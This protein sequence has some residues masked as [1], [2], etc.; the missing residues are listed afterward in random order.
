LKKQAKESC[1]SV[2]ATV[3][4]LI[5]E[6]MGLEKKRT[7]VYNDLDDLAG[8]WSKEDEQAFNETIRAFTKI[9]EDLWK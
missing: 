8:G 2:N 1:T 3:L 6:S 5:R 4:Y 9:D 7:R